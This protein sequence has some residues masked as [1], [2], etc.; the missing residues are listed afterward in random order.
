ME[1]DRC[2]EELQS[3]FSAL[4]LVASDVAAEL[5][6][7]SHGDGAST[8]EREDAA[9]DVSHVGATDQCG[10]PIRSKAAILR[11]E[12]TRTKRWDT[13]RERACSDKALG[14]WDSH[15]DALAIEE[16]PVVADLAPAPAAETSPV[17]A[18]FAPAPAPE[19]AAT[20]DTAATPEAAQ[21]TGSAT[22]GNNRAAE[23]FDIHTG[24]TDCSGSEGSGSW[25]L[26]DEP[27]PRSGSWGSLSPSSS[28]TSWSSASFV[29]QSNQTTQ[30]GLQVDFR[31]RDAD[32]WGKWSKWSWATDRG[33][34]GWGWKEDCA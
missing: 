27:R 12:A 28:W 9:N 13:F 34:Q 5:N 1:L 10:K 21:A 20:P 3:R 16:T 19:T 24:S 32:N 4:Q 17:V 22:H 14:R 31:V 25:T 11:R 15:E 26:A 2:R 8:R 33:W 30:D 18:D 29:S 6:A 23:Y 7:H